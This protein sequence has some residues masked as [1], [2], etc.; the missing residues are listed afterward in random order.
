M[1]LTILAKYWKPLAIVA[2]SALA[3]VYVRHLGVTATEA[4]YK[5]I[6]AAANLAR[7]QAIADEK[8][9]TENFQKA[10]QASKGLQ[11]ELQK[12]RV[13]VDSA[14]PVGVRCHV[15]SKVVPQTDTAGGHSAAGAGAGTLP[16]E[17]EHNTG[18][19]GSQLFGLADEA[20]RLNAQLRACQAWATSISQ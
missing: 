1:W 6:V 14:P 8:A 12:L 16:A 19:I 11:D 20:D 2:V 15:T 13:I 4:K 10:Q 18:D 7:D 17:A 9:A 3:F 5:P